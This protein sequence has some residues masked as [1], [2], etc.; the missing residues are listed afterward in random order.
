MKKLGWALLELKPSQTVIEM[1]APH[2]KLRAFCVARVFKDVVTSPGL[3]SVEVFDA[4]DKRR[5]QL[6]TK[7]N[8]LREIQ[9]QGNRGENWK[10]PQM[11]SQ[12]S[13]QILR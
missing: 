3:G 2:I 10:C 7:R 13:H 11:P 4:E 8:C 5:K 9:F 6:Q 12:E 1:F